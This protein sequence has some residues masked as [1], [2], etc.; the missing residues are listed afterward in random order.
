MI[1]VIIVAVVT[2]VVGVVK[3]LVLAG[4]A[5]S[6]AY[7]PLIVDA[8]ADVE[9]DLLSGVMFVSEFIVPVSYFVEVLC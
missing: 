8:W 6:V 9:N 7:T 1:V 5:V 2:V 3:V 4:I